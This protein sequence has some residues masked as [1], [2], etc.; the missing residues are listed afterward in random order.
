MRR[1]DLSLEV[2]GDSPRVDFLS[3]VF[4]LE[5][6]GSNRQNPVSLLSELIGML[7]FLNVAC[8]A[9]RAMHRSNLRSFRRLS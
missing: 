1:T 5:V 2:S 8:T 7:C 4:C 6:V 9:H 3:V